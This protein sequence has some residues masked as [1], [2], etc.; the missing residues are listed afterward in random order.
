MPAGKR[1][2]NWNPDTARRPEDRYETN[3]DTTI[4]CFVAGSGV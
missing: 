4:D 1:L 3:W 2:R